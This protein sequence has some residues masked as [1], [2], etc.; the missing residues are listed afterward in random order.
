MKSRFQGLSP[1]SNMGQELSGS[2][3]SSSNA[4]GSEKGSLQDQE[5]LLEG[6]FTLDGRRLM[7]KERKKGFLRKVFRKENSQGGGERGNVLQMRMRSRPPK[8]IS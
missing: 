8:A 5:H 2:T 3:E 1:R 6:D 4:G 7:S